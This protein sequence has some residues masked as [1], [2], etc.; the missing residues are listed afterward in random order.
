[1]A[2][3]PVLGHM[4]SMQRQQAVQQLIPPQHR[5][6]GGCGAVHQ[7]RPH[8]HLQ[9]AVVE[10]DDVRRRCLHGRCCGCINFKPCKARRYAPSAAGADAADGRVNT[11]QIGEYMYS[12]TSLIGY[13]PFPEDPFASGGIC[14]RRYFCTENKKSVP[15]NPFSNRNICL[16]RIQPRRI[17]CFPF[18]VHHM[19]L[20]LVLNVVYSPH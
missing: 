7:H 14:F 12:P 9:P 17:H 6:A 18:V 11:Y 10:E 5:E 16:L 19:S 4:G 15:E 2:S 20:P 1:M 8:L 13:G 3:R